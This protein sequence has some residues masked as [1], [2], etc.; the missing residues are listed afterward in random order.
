MGYQ[1]GWKKMS[2][3]SE[4]NADASYSGFGKIAAE[5]FTFIR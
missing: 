2:E 3:I 5:Y 4:T 1:N